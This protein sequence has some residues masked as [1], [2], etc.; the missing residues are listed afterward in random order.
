MFASAVDRRLLIV[1]NGMASHGLCERLAKRGLNK[2]LDI[3]V[4]GEERLPAY[5]R[6]RIS[7]LFAGYTTDSLLLAKQ[8]WYANH[9]V[10]LV[11]SRRVVRIDR[12]EKRVVT[13][14]GETQPYDHLVL[15]TGSY[16]WVPPIPGADLP[17]VFVYRTIDDLL[18]IRDYVKSH[19]CETAA[20]LGGGLLGL[21]AVK[22]LRD[23]SVTTT[24]IDQAPGLMPRQ[25][26]ASAAKVLCARVTQLGV[27]I[28]LTHRTSQ[29]SQEENGLRLSFDNGTSQRVDLV[30]VSAGV[31]PRDELAAAAELLTGS[32]GGYAVDRRLRT[33]DEAISAI[34]ECASIDD[35]VHGLVAPCYQ[36]A[37]VLVDQLA[38]KSNAR[39]GEADESAELK[40][41]GIPVVSLGK[42]I[43]E[44]TDGVVLTHHEGDAIRQILVEHDRVT[45]AAAVGSWDDISAVRLAIQR[46]S[47]LS[48]RQRQRFLDTGNI[49]PANTLRTVNDWPADAI[50]CSCK[51]ITRAQLSRVTTRGA[52]TVSDLA[53]ATGA[54][55]ACGS[56]RP[57]L[58]QL[59][60]AS[61]TTTWQPANIGL[62]IISC[63]ALAIVVYLVF[64]P[65][66][67]WATSVQDSQREIDIWWRDS[68]H[69]QITGY[70]I[71]GMSLLS[72]LFTLKKR[73]RLMPLGSFAAWRILHGLLGTCALATIFAHTGGRLGINFNL[74]LVSIFIA[75]SVCGAGVGMASLLENTLSGELSVQ[76]RSLRPQL[77]LWH[78][79]VSAML[80]I[81]LAI[82]LY[83]VYWY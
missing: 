66:I 8:D 55:T 50:V 83:C 28:L 46:R 76:L 45:G 43:G 39:F 47:K 27:D 67:D 5:D 36:M 48:A 81:L 29:I 56:C 78:I 2:R 82:H 54:S 53:A 32:R 14:D 18:A 63:L 80:P 69:K 23:L 21:E 15:A 3:T 10:R 75:A 11:T 65:A 7:Q 33:N 19:H 25:L 26:N 16:A 6:V 34:G 58:A 4:I 68:V 71:G 40:L 44:S 37:D 35:H 41:L 60:G 73:T 59:V 74:A 77:I 70:S 51:R 62:A 12:A 52:T 9:N 13:D 61:T 49:S 31:R 79:V 22:V 1:G 24:V 72:L 38:G 20:V 30:I 42:S 64:F 17:G 57:L